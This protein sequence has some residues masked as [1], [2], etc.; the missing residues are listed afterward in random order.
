MLF[1]RRRLDE[2]DIV[3]AWVFKLLKIYEDEAGAVLRLTLVGALLQAGVAIGV[4]ASS[5]LFL[6]HLGAAKL[7]Y[8]YFVMPLLMAV[9]VPVYSN[10]IEKRGVDRMINATLIAL[11]LGGVTL[12]A[13]LTLLKLASGGN[14][15]DWLYY[16][17]EIYTS[18][19][20]ILI[21]TILWMFIEEYFDI[22]SAK[23]LFPVLGGGAA[24]GAMFGG[25]VVAVT[26]SW[27][28]V[29]GL[30]LLWAASALAA[31]PIVL[32]LR[33]TTHKVEEVE[34]E[35]PLSFAEQMRQV[36]VA[37]KSSPYVVYLNLAIILLMFLTTICEYQYLSVFEKQGDEET[38]ATLFGQLTVA[39][40]VFH[41]VVSVFFFNRLI[42]AIGVRNTALIQPLAYLGIFGIF[43][44]DLNFAAAI[45]G[46][47]VCNGL[48]D[49]IEDNN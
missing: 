35:E 20:Q 31:Y 32:Q 4:S 42:S 24:L 21:F 9:I 16:V 6:T 49:A 44:L 39:V 47:F 46:F 13:G 34:A 26:A 43:V 2:V 10:L 38:L 37:F 41:L 36:G 23:R 1:F 19:W 29:A 5:S 28:G 3:R 48:Q 22:L 7:P 14:T 11:A 33:R 40:N 25:G 12:F 27:I 30:F 45:I 17:I 18:L 8:V 15:G